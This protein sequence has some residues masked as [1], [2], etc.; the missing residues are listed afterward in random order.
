MAYVNLPFCEGTDLSDVTHAED[1]HDFTLG[2]M[3]S[4]NVILPVP[5]AKLENAM[6]EIPDRAD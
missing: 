6:V 3:S 4:R 2:I 5:S 1:T